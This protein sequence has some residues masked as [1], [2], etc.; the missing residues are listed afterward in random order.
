MDPVVYYID[1]TIYDPRGTSNEFGVS[2]FA[3]SMRRY[4]AGRAHSVK[5]SRSPIGKNVDTPLLSEIESVV[6][7]HI[8]D[9]IDY[10]RPEHSVILGRDRGGG[11]I[12]ITTKSGDKVS[13]NRQFELKDHIPLGYQKYKEYKEY[14]SPILSSE[15]DEYDIKQS[16]TLMWI[17][18]VR[19]GNTDSEINLKFPLSYDCDIIV[20]GISSDGIISNE[21]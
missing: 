10:L 2:R 12:V 6:P 7:F 3:H 19:F 1:G 13:W 20:E 18:S 11:A 8:I 15:A 14:A 16:P 17:P 4:N 9:R 21:L 5:P